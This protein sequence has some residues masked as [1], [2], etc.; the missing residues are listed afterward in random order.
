MEEERPASAL[1][2]DLVLSSVLKYSS[3]SDLASSLGRVS[4]R[5]RELSAH[6]SVWEIQAAH[7]Y[8]IDFP[9]LKHIIAFAGE[10]GGCLGRARAWSAVQRRWRGIDPEVATGIPRASRSIRQPQPQ[11][12]PYQPSSAWTRPARGPVF[13]TNALGHRMFAHSGED[14]AIRISRWEPLSFPSSSPCM[15][16]TA[17]ARITP[18]TAGVGQ[19]A[20]AGS[21]YLRHIAAQQQRV[22][23]SMDVGRIHML[24]TWPAHSHGVLALSADISTQTLVSG[25]W[26]GACKVWALHRTRHCDCQAVPVHELRACCVSMGIGV[27]DVPSGEAGRATFVYRLQEVQRLQGQG[28]TQ[29]GTLE[30]HTGTIVAAAHHGDLCVTCSH[31]GT[32]RVWDLK[33]SSPQVEQT[34][35]AWGWSSTTLHD[36]AP[37]SVSA[38]TPLWR[39]ECSVT[40]RGHTGPVDSVFLD[41]RHARVLSGGKDGDVRVWD[42]GT[43]KCVHTFE[44]PD[45]W[46]WSVKSGSTYLDSGCEQP[47]VRHRSVPARPGGRVSSQAGDSSATGA[48]GGPTASNTVIAPPLLPVSSA[49]IPGT[50]VPE[51]HWELFTG[52]SDAISSAQAA[53]Q[54]TAVDP[55]M[56]NPPEFAGVRTHLIRPRA[57]DADEAPYGESEGPGAGAVYQPLGE[58]APVHG[59]ADSS[60]EEEENDQEEEEDEQAYLLNLREQYEERR[61]LEASLGCRTLLERDGQGEEITGPRPLQPYAGWTTEEEAEDRNEGEREDDQAG[62]AEDADES[63]DPLAVTGTTTDTTDRGA[64][65]VGDDGQ[66]IFSTGTDGWIRLYDLR[67]KCAVGKTY[68]EPDTPAWERDDIPCSG[69]ALQLAHARFVTASFDGIVRV[70]DARMLK[71]TMHLQARTPDSV[72]LSRCDVSHD[73]IAVGASDGSIQMWDMYPERAS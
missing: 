38:V 20:P 57:S 15:V 52:A 44:G 35:K 25:D 11:P 37:G 16:D 54:G 62:A 30:G 66:L 67:S 59:D 29:L 73:T 9:Y 33:L 41:T 32:V 6:T 26:H 12:R 65:G 47:G 17:A 40:M 21:G 36:A 42:I 56:S 7:M 53:A 8:P 4:H 55:L 19:P 43:G 39:R 14:G 13:C 58:R 28:H 51:A 46:V 50:T 34:R 49:G 61:A 64:C 5:W 71:P 70:W 48:T 72:S 3:A 18:H 2:N 10:L 31:D 45:A 27:R 24:D 22:T 60:E 68:L 1:D 69:L 63:S 23:R